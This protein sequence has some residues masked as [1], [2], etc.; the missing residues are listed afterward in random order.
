MVQPKTSPPHTRS[1]RN[2]LD[3]RRHEQFVGRSAQKAL[4]AELLEHEGL[5]VLSFAAAGGM[6]K[7]SL[8]HELAWIARERGLP[9]HYVD[10]AAVEP[11]AERM[12][13][14]IAPPHSD[15]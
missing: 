8:L 2:L 6:G 13:A 3:T 12:A 11:T 1:I 9:A 10:C 5:C 14:A 15:H 4:F 7:T